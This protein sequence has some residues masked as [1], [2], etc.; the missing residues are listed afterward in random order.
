MNILFIPANP[1][2]RCTHA[3]DSPWSF[4]LR[5]GFAVTLLAGGA[6]GR[7]KTTEQ[8][9]NILFILA[10]DLTNLLGCYGDLLLQLQDEIM[11]TYHPSGQSPQL[12]TNAWSPILRK[13]GH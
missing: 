13:Q 2:P 9:P 11:A 4:P 12:L 8:K 6:P 1:K 10:D 3:A 5:I 7:A